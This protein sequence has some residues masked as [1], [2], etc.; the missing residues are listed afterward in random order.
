LVFVSNFKFNNN[1]NLKFEIKFPKEKTSLMHKLF[2]INKWII[3]IIVQNYD[4]VKQKEKKKKRR[5]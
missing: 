2:I 5:K 1:F 4:L 3:K